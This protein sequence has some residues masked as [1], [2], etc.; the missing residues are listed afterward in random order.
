MK[1]DATLERISRNYVYLSRKT[2][3]IGYQLKKK[4][5]N[6]NMLCT[7]I[8]FLKEKLTHT[9]TPTTRKNRRGCAINLYCSATPLSLCKDFV[10]TEEH[11][12][13]FF[14]LRAFALAMPS[15]WNAYNFFPIQLRVHAEQIQKL[16]NK[17][18]TRLGL[19]SK[20]QIRPDQ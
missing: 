8:F 12:M 17:Q 6:Q 13:F 14:C 19:P 9:D 5:I 20:D 7:F 11:T 18:K 10:P 4:K 3:R 2:I 15:S 16:S 1:P